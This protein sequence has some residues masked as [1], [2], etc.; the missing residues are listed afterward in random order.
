VCRLINAGTN[1]DLVRHRCSYTPFVG[2]AWHTRSS[3]LIVAVA[4]YADSTRNR[5]A[6]AEAAKAF[7]AL[8]DG[9]PYVMIHD[10]LVGGPKGEEI[11]CSL[12]RWGNERAA[13]TSLLLWT[14]HCELGETEPR[15]LGAGPD[16]DWVY[17]TTL[18][19]DLAAR[20]FERWVIVVDACFA[21]HVLEIVTARL[22]H[23]MGR[24][25]DGR[26]AVL[27]CV[28]ALDEADAGVFTAALTAVL[29]EGPTQRWWSRRQQFLSLDTVLGRLEDYLAAHHPG[30]DP[31]KQS[32]GGR[33][34]GEC[35]PNP[36]YI[37]TAVAEAMD[38]AHFLPKARGIE[39]GETGWFFTGRVDALQ[40]IRSWLHRAGDPLLV[41]TGSAGTGK[42]AILGR[43]IT[44][45]VPAYR[46]KAEAAG[47]LAGAVAGTVPDPGDV[48]LAFHARERQVDDLLRF[49]A[50]NLEVPTAREV[51]D[52][53]AALEARAG[54]RP[55]G[56]TIALDALDEAA[57]GHGRRMIDEIVVPLTCRPGVKFLIGTRPGV[58]DRALVP[59]DRVVNLDHAPHGLTDIRQYARERLL[60]VEGS[61]Y[62]S[63]PDLA[64]V[65]A[66][67]VAGVS[68]TSFL[69]ARVITKTLASSATL[70]VTRQ[71]WEAMLPRG[72]EAAFEADLAAYGSRHG[73]EL[74]RLLRDLLAALAWDEGQGLPRGLIPPVARAVTGRSYH[75]DDVT[76]L[77][78]FAGGHVTE[79]Q[80]DGWATY[81]LYHEQFRIYLRQVTVAAGPTAA[82]VHARI[83]EA[84]LAAGRADGWS[85]PNPYSRRSLPRH[86][87]LGN[88]LDDVVVEPG[89]LEA[90]DPDALLTVLPLDGAGLPGCLIRT[91]RRAAHALT[92]LRPMERAL[93]LDVAEAAGG[94]R[95]LAGRG[96]SRVRWRR[97]PAAI[98]LQTLT[99]HTGAVR[100][101]ALGVWDA[102]TSRGRSEPLTGHNGEVVA[103][104]FGL[105][106][107]DPVIVSHGADGTVRLW[108]ARAGRSYT[109]PLTGHNGEVRAIAF[110]VADGSPAIVSG[111]WDRA[112]QLWNARAGRTYAGPLTGHNGEVRAIALGV[113][114]GDPVIVSGSRDGTVQIWNARAG[115]THGQ[116]LTGHTGPVGAVGIGLI[117]GTPVI[118]SGGWDGTVRLWDAHTCRPRGTP[119]TGHTAPVGA[120]G[121]RL[122]GGDLVIVSGSSDGTVRLWNAHTGQA[123]GIPLTGHADVVRAVGFGMA[124]EGPVI[125][126]GAEDGTV[127]LWDARTGRAR[128]TPLVGHTDPV[129]VVGSGL[130]DGDPVI[131]SGSHDGSVRLW[132]ARTGQAR[133]EPLTGSTCPVGAVAVGVIDGDPVIVSGY[134]DGTV[135]LWNARTSQP[136]STP[137]VGHT[138]PVFAV[139]AGIID[140]DPVIVSGYWDGTVQLWNTRTS[141]PHGTPLIGHT[142]WV[143]AVAVG[144]VDQDPVIA[145][146]GLDGTVRLW[147]ARSGQ[148]RGQPLTGHGAWV[149]A[150]AFGMLGNDPVIASGGLDGTVRLW[151]ARSGSLGLVIPALVEV[152]AV[153]IVPGGVAVGAGASV[154]VVNVPGLQPPPADRR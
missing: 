29:R 68:G 89:Y 77:L 81:R 84:L 148:P 4:E 135:R 90:A 110:A 27:S 20:P 122:V 75:D 39:A 153:G 117:D 133:G 41:I 154:V 118:V 15:L 149:V 16:G 72:L 64:E 54:A 79:A 58:I 98:E 152:H 66:A 38:E 111:G 11:L 80:T 53:F 113:L 123:H 59:G 127:R 136:H 144:V 50:E 107:R 55:R 88:R 132:N 26:F 10:A 51:T 106:E 65:V 25:R 140:G 150:V 102:R 52:L 24:M 151:D 112:V 44:L 45:S 86:A 100:A 30:V 92:P 37:E 32:T 137:L 17:A 18:A 131:V 8:F 146:G 91:Y 128:G 6:C 35:F 126:S 143:R 56:F 114:D 85:A 43:V 2:E 130:V 19:N 139:A 99:G 13:A 42:S 28:G 83:T 63:D 82:Q 116:P 104:T 120:V 97:G 71:G 74:E 57:G 96:P 34:L 94:E 36:L 67:A 1:D 12:R 23:A 22:N 134:W 147:D 121:S 76:A 5:P 115:Q 48:Q 109:G 145:S 138:G 124:D 141:Q 61:P 14:G 103:V 95:R 93:A 40:R 87:A 21:H 78:R 73:A 47:I 108:D 9:S 62:A 69:I 125:V 60:R 142:D 31:P 33:R 49:L 129:G 3:V 119:L 46:Q 105:V 7:R 101:V 70:D